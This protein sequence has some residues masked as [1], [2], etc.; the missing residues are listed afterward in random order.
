[1]PYH[2]SETRGTFLVDN[3]GLLCQKMKRRENIK[4]IANYLFV[5]PCAKVSQCRKDLLLW[6]GID[7]NDSSRGTYCFYF[8]DKWSYDWYFKKYWEYINGKVKRMHLTTEG[9]SLYD[10]DLS[11]RIIAW[12]KEPRIKFIVDDSSRGKF[13]GKSYQKVFSEII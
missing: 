2:R 11:E 12:N 6:R 13:Q 10:R 8:Y 3:K 4:W 5:N 9:L 7:V 1:M